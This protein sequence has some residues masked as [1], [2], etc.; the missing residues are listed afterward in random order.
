[1]P[2]QAAPLSPSLAPAARATLV[3][4]V[5]VTVVL[6]RRVILE[7]VDLV[8]REGEHVTIVGPNGAGK[9]TLV[10]VVLG[11]LAPS[12]GRVSLRPG[13]RIGY[14]PQHLPIERTIPI[15]V[16][17]FLALA[18]R[19]S[20]EER[21]AVLAEVGLEGIERRQLA[22]L[23]GGQLRRVLLARALLRRP[24]LLVLDEPLSGVDLDGRFELYELVA[25]IRSRYRCAVLL[26]SHDLHIVMATTDRVVCLDRHVCCTGSP[27]T[28][29]RD[30]RFA[31][32]FGDRF[33]SVVA[34]YRHRHPRRHDDLSRRFPR[35]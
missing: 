4:L 20:L 10:K 32:L 15:D 16:E 1:M 28:I 5:D 19:R 2:G 29:A 11:L 27:E 31:R 34:L 30:P 26:V 35:P 9:T 33:G 17:G 14:A 8:V 25:A 18:G 22:A 13:V 24:E 6:D 21:R 23:S 7:N 3:E 12:A